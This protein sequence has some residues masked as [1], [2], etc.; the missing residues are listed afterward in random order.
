MAERG[1]TQNSVRVVIILCATLLILEE[2]ESGSQ[3]RERNTL[4]TKLDDQQLV[5]DPRVQH[6]SYVFEETGETIPYA[7]FVPGAYDPEINTPLLVSLHGLTR[8]H[9]WLM[10]YEGLLDHADELNFVVVTPLGY[11][12]QGWYGSWSQGVDGRSLEVEG[13]YSQQDVMNVVALV[14]EAYAIDL[15]RMYLW[16]HSM[17]GAGTYHLAMEYPDMWAATAVVAPAVPQVRKPS[18]LK[19]IQHIPMLVLQG[20]RDRLVH[21]TRVWVEEMR[22]L[23]MNVEYDEMDG[24]DHSLFISKNKK[25]V[26]RL[27]DFFDGKTR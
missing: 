24:A 26:R 19:L 23:N 5:N 22:G 21:S 15:E 9:D 13:V 10:G 17:G 11:T 4:R 2:V 7:L 18:D 3:M 25:N 14:Q 6:L 20:T 1:L 27:L 8:T 12:R 16:G